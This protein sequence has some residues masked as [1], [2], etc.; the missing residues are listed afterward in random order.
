[1]LTRKITIIL[2]NIGKQI[3]F[4]KA[5][6]SNYGDVLVRISRDDKILIFGKANC[7]RQLTAIMRFQMLKTSAS[8]EMS[9]YLKSERLLLSNYS[10]FKYNFLFDGLTPCSWCLCTY[11]R[12]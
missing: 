9:A 2:T 10:V 5:S 1:M 12:K 4:P 7:M 11:S 8:D 6:K 3:L